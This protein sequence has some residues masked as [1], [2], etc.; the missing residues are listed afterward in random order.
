MN[1]HGQSYLF[2]GLDDHLQADLSLAW[3]HHSHFYHLFFS[4]RN[5][6]LHEVNQDKLIL[7]CGDLVSL[8]HRTVE[9]NNAKVLKFRKK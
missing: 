4:L 9:L 2:L 7:L 1:S 6:Y 3:L 8:I 5:C